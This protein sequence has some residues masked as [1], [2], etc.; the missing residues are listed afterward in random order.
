MTV[1]L[2]V[3]IQGNKIVDQIEDFEHLIARPVKVVRR[4]MKWDDELVDDT[5]RW[6]AS[7]GHD[8]II[9]LESFTATQGIRWLD[10]A[11]GDYDEDLRIKGQQ[12]VDLAWQ[13][14][15]MTIYL[16][17]H[18]E[19]EDDV[20]SIAAQGACGAGPS[21]F[22]AASAH[23]RSFWRGMGVP[24]RGPKGHK[25]N[26]LYG[27]C[28]MGATYRGG[29]GGASLWFPPD[30]RGIQFVATDGYNRGPCEEPRPKWRTF[31]DVFGAAHDF[32]TSLAKPFVIQE[33]GLPENDAATPNKAAWF[34]DAHTVM[35]TWDNLAVFMYSHVF[36]TNYNCDYHV[37]TSTEALDAYTRI[38][39]DSAFLG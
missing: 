2:G 7:T 12:I 5:T 29:H 27:H 30:G 32:A 10:I 26:V 37:N 20:D 17:F 38:A 19:P 22:L 15:N 13:N 3:G 6:A 24:F 39:H 8:A 18:H 21:E 11:A 31:T 4:Y 9:A 33:C 25:G 1:K 28:L 14:P 16:E 35:E 34:D 23:V 36:S